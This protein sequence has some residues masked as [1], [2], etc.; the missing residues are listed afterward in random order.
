[1]PFGR[2]RRR[3]LTR[4]QVA[5]LRRTPRKRER[6]IS[7]YEFPA[8]L[9]SRVRKRLPQAGETEWPLVELGLREWFICCAWRGNA[10]LG[11]PSRAVDEAWHEFILNSIAYIDF[12][13]RAFGDYLHHT[14]DE[15]M[16]TPMG[17]ALG[18]TVRAWDRSEA[19]QQWESVL[20]DLDAR[21][22]I[23]DPLGIDEL[24]LAGVRSRTP[25]YPAVGAP[26][27]VPIGGGGEAGGGGCSG[28]EGGGCS[29]G[30]GGGGGGGG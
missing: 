22:G 6:F 30:C 1:M 5:L 25:G 18:E 20:W 13:E 3:K 28:G 16:A 12:C 24:Q 21:L 4:V 15:A 27:F 23:A 7:E 26:C 2:G 8:H 19:G 11:M 29:G 10:V 14:P 17:N 9:A